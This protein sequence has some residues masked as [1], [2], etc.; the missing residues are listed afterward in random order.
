LNLRATENWFGSAQVTVTATDPAR[1]TAT[2]TVSVT[3]NAVNDEPVFRPLPAVTFNEDETATLDLASYVTDVEDAPSAMNWSASGT[4]NVQV[5]F[6]GTVATFSARS[7]W[8]GTEPV[9]ITVRDR[10]GISKSQTVQVTVNSVNDP[11]VVNVSPVNMSAGETR[12]ID[13]N[14]FA[15]D[16]DGDALRWSF[17]RQT[18]AL[19][20]QLDGSVL[21]VT[22]P[23][24]SSGTSV[25]TLTVSDG[26][27]GEET[28]R[29][30]VNVNP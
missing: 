1:A 27:G 21:R 24:G 6:S 3:V 12:N 22:A 9:T 28:V 15:R 18:G 4:Q 10:G 23:A 8:H 11:P 29:L 7:N 2:A 5:R 19:D 25:M 13:L 30:S 14:A 26:K 20:V 17:Q 16:P